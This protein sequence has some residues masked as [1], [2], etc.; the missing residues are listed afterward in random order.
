MLKKMSLDIEKNTNVSTRTII[1]DINIEIDIEKVFRTLPFNEKIQ[2]YPCVIIEPM[3]FK[4]L[5][6]GEL[7]IIPSD[8]N[9]EKQFLFHEKKTG[10]S[11]RN[12]V[13]LIIQFEEKLINIKV[14]RHGNFQITGSKNKEQGYRAICYFIELCLFICPDA[15]IK[16]SEFIHIYFYT[17]MTNIVF[18]VKFNID[19]KKLNQI[20]QKEEQFYNLFE[21]NFGYTG[22]NIKLPL[23]PSWKD[24]E[25][26]YFTY[27]VE[28]KKWIFQKIKYQREQT[29][30]KQKFNTFLVF[31]S[32]KIIM[33]GMCEENMNEHYCFFR[34][35]IEK[36]RDQI[37]EKIF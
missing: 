28:E 3:Y 27:S 23:P 21:T 33:S 6:K 18:D 5:S 16:R 17:V 9:G 14:S 22:M 11:F 13:N 8:K 36:H 30:E 34:N 20:I 24:F 29:K 35:F 19:K 32:G 37:E 15:I 12:A 1:S 10:S 7:F 4:N 25:I 26:P 31:H 2:N